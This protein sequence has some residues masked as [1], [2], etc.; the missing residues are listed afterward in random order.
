MD[1]PDGGHA[2]SSQE[3][4]TCCR[5]EITK[6]RFRAW[7]RLLNW[8]RAG[9]AAPGRIGALLRLISARTCEVLC[10]AN[11]AG[12]AISVSCSSPN[13]L[14][15]PSMRT[16]GNEVVR[17]RWGRSATGRSRTKSLAVDDVAV[18][19]CC[20][21]RLSLRTAQYRAADQILLL[22]SS[23][24][25]VFE[26]VLVYPL[27][28]IGFLVLDPDVVLDHK[29][30]K[31]ATVDQN[32]S[33]GNTLSVC[34]SIRGEAAGRDEDATVRL[35]ALESSDEGL[36]LGPSN[37]LFRPVSLCLDVDAIE[38][39]CIL[40]VVRTFPGAMLKPVDRP[41]RAVPSR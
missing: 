41:G 26:E 38:A 23:S 24:L 32:H 3:P 20:T 22:H 1:E 34:G 11:F 16:L 12:M 19:A 15:T 14:L 35:G 27:N 13:G 9:R 30:C 17:G 25:D 4:R 39:E 2:L 31:P 5:S 21:V 36:D 33:G 8:D 28:D 7:S 10:L 37:R 29:L 18:L 40:P 6:G